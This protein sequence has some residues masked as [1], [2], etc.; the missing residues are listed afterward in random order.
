MLENLVLF[1]TLYIIN[2]SLFLNLVK[3]EITQTIGVDFTSKPIKVNDKNIKL[4]IWD[5]A[6][7][8]RYRSMVKNYYRGAI[9]VIIIYDITKKDSFLHVSSW[10]KDAKSLTREDSSI[11]LVGNKKDLKSL[12]QVKVKDGENFSEENNILFLE[13]SALTG[14]NI[15]EVFISLSKHLIDKIENGIIDSSSVS[16]LGKFN[17]KIKEVNLSSSNKGKCQG[18]C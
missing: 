17:S 3:S 1:I 7:Q 12:R 5:T 8:E 18:Y 4:Q 16:L 15:E 9:G 6:G 13:T 2:V 10:L 14:E 11:F